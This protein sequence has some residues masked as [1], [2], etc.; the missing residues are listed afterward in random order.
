[1]RVPARV[2]TTSIRR[3]ET[4]GRAHGRKAFERLFRSGLVHAATTEQSPPAQVDPNNANLVDNLA[5]L[6]LAVDR[7]LPLHGRI[8]PAAELFAA[9]GSQP[10]ATRL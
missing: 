3:L 1:M 5:K 2:A 9:T 8:A 4:R 6:N 10:A 7:I